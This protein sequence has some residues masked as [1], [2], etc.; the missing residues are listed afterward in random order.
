MLAA[1]AVTLAP[2]TAAACTWC[3]SSAF[4]D[5]SYNWAYLG[6][7]LAPFGIS[8]V[9]GGVLAWRYRA[10]RAPAPG[11]AATEPLLDKETP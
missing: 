7:I 1:L 9:I 4:G 8:L 3:L 11:G 10:H 2:G 5:R 6:L